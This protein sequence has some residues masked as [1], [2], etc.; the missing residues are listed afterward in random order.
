MSGEGSQIDPGGGAGSAGARGA[1]GTI[2]DWVT[3]QIAEALRTHIGRTWLYVNGTAIAARH[4]IDVQMEGATGEDHPESDLVRAILTGGGGG[5]SSGLT[6]LAEFVCVGGEQTVRLPGSGGLAVGYKALLCF[7]QARA[8]TMNGTNLAIVVRLNGDTTSNY[9]YVSHAARSNGGH[10]AEG[11]T[12]GFT[13]L[14]YAYVS[15]L[16]GADAVAGGATTSQL[17]LPMASRSVFWQPILAHS[18]LSYWDGIDTQELQSYG[19]WMSTTVITDVTFLAW[20]SGSPGLLSGG[21]A[22]GSYF[23]VYGVS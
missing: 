9:R 7:A 23:S 13:S 10:S 4:K 17:W 21:F 18:V 15:R 3:A 6:L 16:A 1:L 12:T 2:K 20:N 14:P 19:H 5:G 11:T 8:A 22:P